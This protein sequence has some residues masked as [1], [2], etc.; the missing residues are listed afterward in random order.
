[1]TDDQLDQEHAPPAPA[2]PPVPTA[3]AASGSARTGR[4]PS[5]RG[6]VAAVA[7]AAVLAAL[8][9]I[10]WGGG[11]P[12]RIA[13]HQPSG[14][15]LPDA[16]GSSGSSGSSGDSGAG[17]ATGSPTGPDPT[18]VIGGPVAPLDATLIAPSSLLAGD[19]EIAS[20]THEWRLAGRVD[21][22]SQRYL[23]HFPQPG[24]RI[25]GGLGADHPS[26]NPV[27]VFTIS[28]ID[29]SKPPVGVMY[30]LADPADPQ[31]QTRVGL[32]IGR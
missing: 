6:P 27:H 24:Y 22:V 15:D 26:G 12:G 16:T 30:F 14:V 25:Y 17:A 7:A 5:V 21:V 31:N 28:P 19:H 20:A 11:E 13:A 2:P 9:I 29:P 23:D 4:G 32:K 1:M 3:P 8:A 10:A 18:E